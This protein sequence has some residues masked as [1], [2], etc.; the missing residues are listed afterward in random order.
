MTL[1]HSARKDKAKRLQ[2]FV[3]KKASELTGLPWGKDCPIESRQM[4]ETGVDV[5]LDSE[6]R[7]LFPFS[8]ECKNQ[9]TWSVPGWIDQAKANCYPNTYWAL[10]LNRNRHSPIIVMDA[11]AFFAL[12]A[13]LGAESRKLFPFSFECRN[14][15][16]WPV[17]SWIEQAKA[18]CYPNT[19]WILGLNRNR[20]S[21]V[22]VMDAEAFFAL[23]AKIAGVGGKGLGYTPKKRMRRGGA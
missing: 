23:L 22:V 15:E 19:Y 10:C 9:E 2:K 7:K 4:G 3:A 18:N 5:R 12:L 20:H 14:K 21:P 16:T 11:E 17:F 13:K 6:A 1:T 8:F